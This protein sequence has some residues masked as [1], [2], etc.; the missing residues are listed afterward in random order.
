MK[1]IL[2]GLVVGITTVVFNSA[3]VFAEP[4]SE[5]TC[6]VKSDG[7]NVIVETLET[8]N[9]ENDTKN[10]ICE[11]DVTETV[12]AEED[13]SPRKL[14]DLSD[15]NVTIDWTLK[16]SKIHLNASTL[17][18]NSKEINVSIKAD[19]KTSLTVY[20]Y[21]ASDSSELASATDT[22]GTT[23]SKN[24]KFTNLTAARTYRIGIMT[25]EQ[26]ESTISG[27]ITD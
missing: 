21:N 25:H 24:F 2:L 18:T 10:S 13:I 16:P 26:F 1:R 22:V 20:L 19:P 14:I 7:I 9:I 6:A 5:H 17:K 23:L 3:V 8:E 11:F 27:K 12:C 15:Y 4:I